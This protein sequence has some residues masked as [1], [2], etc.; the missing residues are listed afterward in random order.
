MKRLQIRISI[1]SCEKWDIWAISQSMSFNSS[2][3]RDKNKKESDLI[4]LNFYQL[5]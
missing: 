2:P 3:G 1:G 5:A 4:A